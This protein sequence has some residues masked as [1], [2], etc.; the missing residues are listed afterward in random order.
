MYLLANI[1]VFTEN[2][3]ILNHFENIFRELDAGIN[4]V[5]RIEDMELC[6]QQ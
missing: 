1:K 5:K 3:T 4:H 6:R 2:S